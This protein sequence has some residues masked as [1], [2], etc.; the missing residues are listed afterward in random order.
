MHYTVIQ[1][2]ISKIQQIKRGVAEFDF[3]LDGNII[4]FTKSQTFGQLD[5]VTDTVIDVKIRWSGGLF[6]NHM[7]LLQQ[8][9]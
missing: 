5:I 2:Q 8:D 4:Q 9:S 6:N 3:F 7:L 1:R